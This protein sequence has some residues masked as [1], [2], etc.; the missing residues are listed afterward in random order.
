MVENSLDDSNIVDETIKNSDE[1]IDLEQ[2][3]NLESNLQNLDETF[4]DLEDLKYDTELNSKK[5]KDIISSA[6]EKG[7]F[8]SPE[9]IDKLTQSDFDY[10]SFI[11]KLSQNQSLLYVDESLLDKNDLDFDDLNWFD[12]DKA[13]VEKEV[14]NNPKLYDSFIEIIKNKS[15][16][17]VDKFLK[18]D[19]HRPFFDQDMD[20]S[21]DIVD[22]VQANDVAYSNT[23]ALENS[24]IGEKNNESKKLKEK[25][26]KELSQ[27]QKGGT[28][29][30]NKT[31]ESIISNS[32]FSHEF[33]GLPSNVEVISSYT[34]LDQ[35]LDV[36]NFVNYYR[37][38][39]KTFVRML[40]TRTELQGLKSINKLRGESEVSIIGLINNIVDTKNGIFIDVEDL[41][42]VIRVIVTKDNEEL[43][44][45]ASELV[46]DQAIGVSGFLK[47]NVIYAKTILEPGV[48]NSIQVKKAKEDVN[49]AI[50][51]D[52]HVGSKLFLEKEF[53]KFIDWINGNYGNETHRELGLKT[54]YLI[55]AGD[56][57]D[58]VGVY[59]GQKSELKVTSIKE[60]YDY[61]ACLLS[62]IR[63]DVTII[64]SPGNH[65][66]VRLAEPQPA[67][68][69]DFA[70]SLYKMENVIL[71]SNPSWLRIHNV[72]GF[73]GFKVL[74]YHGYSFDYYI[75]NIDSLRNSGGF[76]RFDL[77]MKFLLNKRHLSPSHGATLFVPDPEK[78]PLVIEEVP[79]I[80]IV[81]HNHRPNVGSF[82]N[83]VLVS[84]GTWQLK[85]PFQEKI[86]HDPLPGRVPVFNLKTRKINLLR[87]VE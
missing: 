7:I 51:S 18:K 59:P 84:G 48:P 44:N 70:E 10:E 17:P 66:A 8:L 35:K 28:Q 67:L 53:M 22:H 12:F 23:P 25:K 13:I 49:L 45:I 1:F 43:Y 37:Q 36:Q 27:N 72:D 26:I 86:G 80:F 34:N 73:S 78:D 11:E 79:D 65:D 57:V 76:D 87:F 60:Q 31:E 50:I 39:L 68:D 69:K 29:K 15:E 6:I 63:K 54:K 19:E 9:V 30:N 21:L 71:V 56:L 82:N 81:G 4:L 20:I 85:T 61:A 3:E 64:I 83:I 47:N 52:L 41:T 75:R 58:G 62:K 38:R 46:L 24:Q 16:F 42:G 5:L 33:E 14:N 40:S 74:I 2:K 55:I 77:V 32:L